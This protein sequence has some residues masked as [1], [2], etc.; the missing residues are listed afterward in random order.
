MT[1][2][3][4]YQKVTST[5]SQQRSLIFIQ[6]SHC[7]IFRCAVHVI[8]TFKIRI[9]N[10]LCVGKNNSSRFVLMVRVRLLLID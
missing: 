5:V 7:K 2:Y 1:L 6:F 8:D 4:K 10:K 9:N 3:Q